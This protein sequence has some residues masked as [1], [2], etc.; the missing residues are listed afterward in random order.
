MEPDPGWLAE[1][2][3]CFFPGVGLL[4]GKAGPE[5]FSSLLVHR[6]GSQGLKLKG[7]EFLDLL[8]MQ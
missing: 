7:L 6:A 3:W 2:P 5:A 4:V 1:G 8:S